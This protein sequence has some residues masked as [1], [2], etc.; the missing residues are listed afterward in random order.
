MRVNNKFDWRADVG[1]I[2]QGFQTPSP[3]LSGY[4]HVYEHVYTINQ[5][6]RPDLGLNSLT[7]S[8]FS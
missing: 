8:W 5:K 7:L 6:D 2:F 1:L 3:S 4:A